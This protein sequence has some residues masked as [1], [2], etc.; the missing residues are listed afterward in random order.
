MFG[1]LHSQRSRLVLVVNGSHLLTF[2]L[3]S[4]ILIVVPGPSVLFTVSRGI[5]FGPLGA[6]LT[7]VGNTIGIAIQGILVAF[8]V[9]TLVEHS[10]LAFDAFRLVGAAYLVYLGLRTV[11][12]ANLAVTQQSIEVEG[13]S[14]IRLVREGLVVGVSNPKSAI[15]LAAVVPGFATGSTDVPL[16]ILL[17]CSIFAV[18]ALVSDSAWGILAGKVRWWLSSNP[19]RLVQLS[20]IG[21]AVIATLGVLLLFV[22]RG[23]H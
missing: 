13:Q 16:Q 22:S 17:L 11:T 19:Y 5:I 1:P 12:K 15:F 23:Y 3:L 18:T 8:G 10:T 20:R 14:R 4:T 6:V 21:G 7:V 2:L 9:G